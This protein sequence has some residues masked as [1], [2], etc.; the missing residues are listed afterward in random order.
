MNEPKAEVV[1]CDAE[2]EPER[3]RTEFVKVKWSGPSPTPAEVDRR[4]MLVRVGVYEILDW[5]TFAAK[6][7][8]QHLVLPTIS[9][10]P[11]DLRIVT[12]RENY[13]TRQFEFLV[14]HPSFAVVPEGECPPVYADMKAQRMVVD[15]SKR[16]A[17]PDA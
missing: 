7:W 9:G 14:A 4:L 11:P 3:R 1:A 13:L 16:E 6:G 15:L 2:N 10:L 5:F 17:K 8:P 12:V